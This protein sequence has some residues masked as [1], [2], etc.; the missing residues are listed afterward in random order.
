MQRNK[1]GCRKDVEHA[2]GV[3]QSRWA[4]AR[5]PARIWSIDTTWEV[6]SCCLIMHNMIVEYER[7]DSIYDKDWQFG[8]ETV[9]PQFGSRTFARWIEFHREMRDKTAHKQFQKDLV[10]HMCSY[11]GNQRVLVATFLI[12]FIVISYLFYSMWMK[13]IH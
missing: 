11:F 5:H 3:I 12:H 6:I 10:H 4:I 2:F 9:V 13:S 1:E 7:D 8:G